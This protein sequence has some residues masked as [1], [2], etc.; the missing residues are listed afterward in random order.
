MKI[1]H[2]NGL[3]NGTPTS[4]RLLLGCIFM[5]L[6][7]ICSFCLIQAIPFENTRQQYVYCIGFSALLSG[8]VT[9]VLYTCLPTQRFRAP[10]ADAVY[11]PLLS[12]MLG[13]LAMTLSYVWL[14][15]F[16]FGRESLMI[17]DMHHQYAPLLS[18]LREMVLH[19]GNPLYTFETGICAN[20]ISLFLYYL[21][22]RLLVYLL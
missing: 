17:V 2:K 22:F 12:G 11:Y 10:Q 7:V 21:F 16:P 1:N 8:L 3:D 15:V 20:F 9:A 18:Q 4:T 14:G 6:T 13:L 19:G 5:L